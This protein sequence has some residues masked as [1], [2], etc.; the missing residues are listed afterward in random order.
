M[1]PGNDKR[2][3]CEDSNSSRSVE[4]I[5]AAA[6]RVT[7]CD[8]CQ[9]EMG[10]VAAY[11]DHCRGKKHLRRTV[12]DRH[13]RQLHQR[14]L[15]IPLA[16]RSAVLRGEQS[17]EAIAAAV[18][19]QSS[20]NVV[21]LL[22]AGASTGAGI[23]DYRS[24]GGMYSTQSGRTAFSIES[25]Q[26][27][28]AGYWERLRQFFGPLGQLQPTQVHRFV[29]QLQRQGMLRRV[30]TQNVDC[31]ELAAGVSAEKVVH[32]H[33]RLDQPRCVDCG[34]IADANLAFSTSTGPPL[35]E[36]C[37]SFVR[38]G[39]VFFDEAMPHSFRKHQAEDLKVCTLLIVIGTSLQVHPF[40]GLVDKCSLL[41]PRLLINHELTGPFC[42]IHKEA[43]SYRDVAYL[44]DCEEGVIHL[45]HLLGL[46]D[47]L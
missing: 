31:L 40:A 8:V 36:A 37:G 14:V 24:C 23:P 32:C 39:F 2:K 38:P 3:D 4:V 26:K 35:C 30:Y 45:T 33:G 25:F 10:S 15:A 5:G 43:Q 42:G 11:A 20:P 22:G 27:D 19:R 1:L 18:S 29:S 16:A 47:D 28:P 12:G 41:T 13:A 9:K 7:W 44:G 6:E 46:H 21:V 17:L 34:A